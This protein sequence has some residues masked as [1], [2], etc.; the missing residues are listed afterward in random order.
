MPIFTPIIGRAS[1]LL[2]INSLLIRTPSVRQKLETALG[3]HFTLYLLKGGRWQIVVFWR[4]VEDV[5]IYEEIQRGGLRSP[6]I[7]LKMDFWGP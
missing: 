1:P 3:V 6:W 5:I 7:R 2:K 4:V